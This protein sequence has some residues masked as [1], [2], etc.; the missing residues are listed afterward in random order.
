[1]L[2]EDYVV[3]CLTAML[4]TYVLLIHMFYHDI[5]PMLNRHLPVQR[6]Y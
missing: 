2:M 4:S 1:M 3:V 6:P 5:V